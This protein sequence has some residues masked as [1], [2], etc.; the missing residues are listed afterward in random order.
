MY[1]RK[2]SSVDAERGLIRVL[3][4]CFEDSVTDAEVDSVMDEVMTMKTLAPGLMT[5]KALAKCLKVS[6]EYVLERM[7]TMPE[8]S[9][10]NYEGTRVTRWGEYTYNMVAIV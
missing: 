3:G 8:G 1:E 7:L 5:A 9:Y 6:D 10:F 4:V 2:K